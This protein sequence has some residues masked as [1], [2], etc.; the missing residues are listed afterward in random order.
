MKISL[1]ILIIAICLMAGATS[2]SM[3]DRH[4]LEDRID[5]LEHKMPKEITSVMKVD[6]IDYDDDKNM[7]EITFVWD[8]T[9]SDIAWASAAERKQEILNL[10]NIK[11][12]DRALPELIERAEAGIEIEVELAD[13]TDAAALCGVTVTFGCVHSG[14]ASG[15]GSLSNTSGVAPAR[16]PASRVL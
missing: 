1:R 9:A 12:I 4:K 8:V 14:L 2:C 3:L 10:V 11:K 6:E 15:R 7:V 13:G 5:Q 16:V